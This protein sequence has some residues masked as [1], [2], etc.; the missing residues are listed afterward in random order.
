MKM[1]NRPFEQ[2]IEK[3]G[4]TSVAQFADVC[5]VF[6]QAVFKHIRGQNKPTVSN[7]VVYANNLG[8]RFMELLEF[9]YPDEMSNLQEKLK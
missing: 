3:A 4:Y 8:M 9:F 5:G 6:P 2:L 1:Q 7:M